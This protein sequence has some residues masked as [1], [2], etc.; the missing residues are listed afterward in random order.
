MSQHPP[1]YAINQTIM[2]YCIHI[3]IGNLSIAKMIQKK[4]IQ[5]HEIFDL[6]RHN[7]QQCITIGNVYLNG[8]WFE[9]NPRSVTR[10]EA[11]P[12]WCGHVACY[13]VNTIKQLGY[14]HF[15]LSMY[16][17]YRKSPGLMIRQGLACCSHLHRLGWVT[18][19]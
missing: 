11:A 2:N 7:L 9:S 8:C 3:D 19:G 14:P 13:L 1:M 18:V 4:Y 5:I 15:Y 17:L 10:A 6:I 12:L 16:L